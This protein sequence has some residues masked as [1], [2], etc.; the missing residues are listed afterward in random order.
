MGNDPS[1][2]L[3]AA[4]C[5][6]S[7]NP[8][9][10]RNSSTTTSPSS[11]RSSNN[12]SSPTPQSSSSSHSCTTTTNNPLT[13][14]PGAYPIPG[15]QTNSSTNN[16]RFAV[17]IPRGIQSGQ[18]FSVLLNGQQI[19]VRCPPGRH[20]GDRLIVTPSR[21]QSQQQQSQPQQFVVTVPPGIQP[22]QQFRA[23]INN[24]EVLVTCP[25]GVLPNQRVR[26]TLPCCPCPSNSNR[27]PSSS[28]SSSLPC[29]A[30]NH[31]MF[32]V[33]VPNGIQ[34]GQSFALVA[35]GQ[36]VMVTCPL[37]ISS[38]TGQRKI[39]FQLP[40]KL[41][42]EQLDLVRVD[43]HKDGWMRCLG[44]DLNFH[45]VYNTTTNTDT[46][47]ISHVM[48]RRN[49][50]PLYHQKCCELNRYGFIR[51][52]IPPVC[53]KKGGK[54]D[55]R[56]I[57]ASLYSMP[58]TV[59]GTKLNYLE[60]STTAIKPFHE[61]CLWLQLQFQQIRIPWEIGHIH[62]KIRRDHL[63]EDSFH[64]IESLSCEDMKKIFR[65]EFIGEAGM[66]CGGVT[67][68]WYELLIKELFNP[69]FGLFQISATNQMCHHINPNSIFP[70]R[71]HSPIPPHSSP[72]PQAHPTE[73]GCSNDNNNPILQYYHFIG[74]IFGKS[75][76]DNQI[77]PIHL[78]T[79]AY[80]YL[81]GYPIKL[82]DLEYIDPEVYCN[83]L[84]LLSVEDV[85][86]LDLDF[87]ITIQDSR[88]RKA[89]DSEGTG[90]EME[91][92]M[93]EPDSGT[94]TGEG[95]GRPETIELIPNGHNIPVTN[96]NLIEYLKEQTKYRLFTRAKSQLC[97]ILR[98]FYEIVPEPFISV[99]N[100]QEL[101]LLLH[102]IPN[103]DITD[104]RNNTEY[105]GEFLLP[106]PP[107]SFPPSV[108][109]GHGNGIG[110][111]NLEAGRDNGNWNNNH[112]ENSFVIAEERNEQQQQLQ[113]NH[114]YLIEWFWEIVTEYSNE[115]RAKLLQ[116]ST[117]TSGVPPQGFGYLQ[118]NDGQIRKFTLLCS[119]EVKVFPRSHTCFNRID[120][121]IYETKEEM[122]K[123][124][125]LA[126]TLESTGFELE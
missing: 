109:D 5:N 104:W 65:I 58:S 61:K 8:N 97:E 60:I 67:R 20:E 115:E 84:G 94:D 93:E 73:A 53:P 1:C 101:E 43:Y 107:P 80:K 62:L 78:I 17:T 7:I 98:G 95:L 108:D 88:Q 52:L 92:G 74:R 126:I 79:P 42:K 69:Q 103:I 83:L 3:R 49:N 14:N 44:S 86:L 19:L 46:N 56:L 41:T 68:E 16:Q 12:S 122:K 110:D 26:F 11:P 27:H 119:S 75:L 70:P 117:G 50:C 111:R 82:R 63:I 124:L 36:R 4:Y 51:E 123:Y 25:P 47:D 118:S 24:R 100:S 114:S 39:R 9:N 91:M 87:T 15:Q 32:E 10:R 105:M 99:F 21:P 48:R 33:L 55:I 125:T 120:L 30:P 37:N 90:M 6:S 64:A 35:N 45:W 54:W 96:A 22:G 18:S 2:P 29:A 28:S 71:P 113:L 59:S 77:T 112:N 38:T 116:F 34:P 106:I 31:Q 89:T 121:P 57:D 85:S 40:I 13:S 66:D 72:S 81:L 23:S 76:M 102:G